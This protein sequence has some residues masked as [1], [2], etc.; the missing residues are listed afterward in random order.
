MTTIHFDKISVKATKRW[1]DAN[2]KKRQVTREFWQTVN[3][4]NRNAA[5]FIK[6]E[7]EIFTEICAMRGFF[8]RRNHERDRSSHHVPLPGQGV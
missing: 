3:Q 6:C 7:D 4:F 2:G 8:N 5:G 1:V